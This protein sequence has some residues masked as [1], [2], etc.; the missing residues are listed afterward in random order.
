MIEQVGDQYTPEYF[1]QIDKLLET[2]GIA[3][4]QVIT[5]PDSR[6]E[7]FIKGIDLI[8][9]HILPGTLL[10]AV[11]RMMTACKETGSLQLHNL[12]NIGPHFAK[13]LRIWAEEIAKN[14][15][16]IKK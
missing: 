16:Q 2:D 13:T 15:D 3:V 1:R 11:S 7:E 5:S 6:Y 14:K 10:A 8:Q 9:K 12:R 4:I